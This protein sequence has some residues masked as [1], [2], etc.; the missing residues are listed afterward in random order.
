MLDMNGELALPE[1]VLAEQ[2][3][4]NSGISEDHLLLMCTIVGEK[5]TFYK[6]AAEG[7]SFGPTTL[8]RSPSFL[9]RV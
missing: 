8:P 9:R 4:A 5:L 2:L 7:R 1:L 3:L 6:V